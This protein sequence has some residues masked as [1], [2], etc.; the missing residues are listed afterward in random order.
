[1]FSEAKFEM[2]EITPANVFEPNLCGYHF[3]HLLRRS[4]KLYDQPDNFS[5]DS[6]LC[7]ITQDESEKIFSNSS[8]KFIIAYKHEDDKYKLWVEAIQPEMQIEE[9][10]EQL[11][12]ERNKILKESRAHAPCQYCFKESILHT[13]APVPALEFLERIGIFDP[14]TKYQRFLYDLR[15]FVCNSTDFVNICNTFVKAVNLLVEESLYT[16]SEETYL[17]DI[18]TVASKDMEWIIRFIM[19]YGNYKYNRDTIDI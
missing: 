1:M 8:T 18:A 10:H 2:E 4:V 17:Y 9:T 5:Q 11:I 13:D 12:S 7:P 19:A 3:V 14:I 16:L 15:K 6:C